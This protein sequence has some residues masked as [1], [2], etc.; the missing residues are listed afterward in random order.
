MIEIEPSVLLGGLIVNAVA[1]AWSIRETF[2]LNG[3]T[4]EL[5]K[6]NAKLQ[7]EVHRLSVHLNQEIVR[8]N[9]I[10]EL[11]RGM[12]LSSMSLRYKA[13]ML[14][15]DKGNDSDKTSSVSISNDEI[16]SWLVTVEGSIIEMRAI[17]NVINDAD[18]LL[19][20]K[21]LRNSVP[22]YREESQQIWL[23]D[24]E[25]IGKNATALHEKV[26]RLLEKAT[27]SA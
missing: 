26:Y 18:L 21:G 4:R 12:Y 23:S 19:L 8:L 9:W 13:G 11:A 7:S 17:A 14:N 10:N 25:E 5:Q 1:V 24:L 15:A 16:T 20:I 3:Q 22:R 27:N 6:S 2:V